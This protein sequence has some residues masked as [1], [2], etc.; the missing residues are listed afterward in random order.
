MI[1]NDIMKFFELEK[2]KIGNKI[3]KVKGVITIPFQLKS[4]LF[5]NVPRIY[6][7]CLNRHKLYIS[8]LDSCEFCLFN[9]YCI[10]RLLN[11]FME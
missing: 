4:A 2:I 3:F 11:K 7:Y 9:K 6:Y 5:E 1:L 10:R 8:R